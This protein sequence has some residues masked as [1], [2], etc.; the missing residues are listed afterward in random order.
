MLRYCQILGVAGLK[1]QTILE[2]V[3]VTGSYAKNGVPPLLAGMVARV[4][5]ELK[6]VFVASPLKCLVLSNS[7]PTL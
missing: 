4:S 1:W 6:E 2:Q 5:L 7:T 3:F